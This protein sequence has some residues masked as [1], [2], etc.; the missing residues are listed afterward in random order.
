MFVDVSSLQAVTE[1]PKETKFYSDKNSVAANPELNLDANAPK[2]D[3]SQT[4][5]AKTEDAAR[6]K[7]DQLMPDPPKPKPEP[8]AGGATQT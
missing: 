2:L 8:E 5:V 1:V 6:K 3:G 4:E 7:F